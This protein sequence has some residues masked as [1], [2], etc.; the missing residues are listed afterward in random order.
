MILIIAWSLVQVQQGPP[1]TARA[2]EKSSALLHC[3]APSGRR[4]LT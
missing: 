4:S 2:D 3:A 1:D